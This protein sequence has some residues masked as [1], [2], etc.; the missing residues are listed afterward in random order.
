MSNL[1]FNS[2]IISINDLSLEQIQLV[3]DT[4]TQLKKTPA[5]N[6]LAGKIVAHCFFEP[7]T[8]TRLSFEA[9]TLRLGGQVIGFS[10]AENISTQKGE[11][12]HDS[13]RVI[14]EYADLIVLRH[15][16]EGTARL[17]AEASMKPIINAGDGANQHPTQALVDLFTIR[18][19]HEKLDN[20]TIA[21]VGD[22][23]HGRTIHS[24]V[25]A[26]AYFNPRLYLIGPELLQ[27]PEYL[28]NMLKKRGVRF[29]LHQTVEEVI[30]KVDILY[31]T[32][33]QQERFTAAEFLLAKNPYTITPAT[34]VKAKTNLKILHP[35]PRVGEI[36]VEVDQTPYAHYFTQAANG[37]PVR[38]ALL[39]L[40]L[41][42]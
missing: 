11:T 2:D 40:L 23:K 12:L 10:D 28:R 14:S 36:A 6:L 35:L 16:H 20:L 5:K 27:L 4:A 22:L 9:A 8:R 15:S 42:K 30:S 1:L 25:Q 34:L 29:S 33:I 19:C 38:Q 17:A 7:S 31:V 18:E 24:F 3:L 26:C 41:N 32:R 21:L 37:I 39:S 13:I